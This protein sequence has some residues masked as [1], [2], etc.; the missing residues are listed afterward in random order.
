MAPDS[1]RPPG[2]ARQTTSGRV[3]V[4]G[5]RQPIDSE[6]QIDMRALRAYRLGRLRDELKRR[7]YAGILL[8]DPIN[9]RYATGARNMTVWTLTGRS[10]LCGFIVWPAGSLYTLLMTYPQS[11]HGR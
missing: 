1:H 2:T 8:Y 7:D 11:R 4:A 10:M 5:T 3:A 6:A 9:I